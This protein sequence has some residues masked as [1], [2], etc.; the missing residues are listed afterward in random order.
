[1][2]EDA[3]KKTFDF[4]P[5]AAAIKRAREDRGIS[6]EELAEECE[7]STG[8][9]KT[10]ENEGR[11]PGF[12][13]FWKLVT[14]FN[15]SVDEFFY[16]ERERETEPWLSNVVGMLKEVESDDI[17]LVES[18]IKGTLNGLVRRGERDKRR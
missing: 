16:P 14:M 9:I 5:I 15:I 10:I 13:L 6:R 1:M 12:Q 11:H 2:S 8:Y 7:V 4:S 17:Y 3:V 18:S